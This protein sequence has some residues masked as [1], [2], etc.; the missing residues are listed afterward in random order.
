M[1]L[2]YSELKEYSNELHGSYK[3]IQE[4]FE[5]IIGIKDQLIKT[6]CW[7]GPAFNYY[8]NKITSLTQN[9]DEV[10]LEL[11]KSALYLDKILEDYEI[12]VNSASKGMNEILDYGNGINPGT[13]SINGS[14][15]TT[16]N[17]LLFFIETTSLENAANIIKGLDTETLEYLK[18]NLEATLKYELATKY[19]ITELYDERI[20]NIINYV[21]EDMLNRF[22]ERFDI[23]ISFDSIDA[24][25]DNYRLL[26]SDRFTEKVKAEGVMAYNDGKESVMNLSYGDDIIKA[27]ISHESIHQLSV[28]DFIGEDG[29]I[30][31]ARGF[32]IDEQN[33][34]FNECATEYLNELVMQDDYPAEGYS[35]YS[36]G[37]SK[38][39]K[40]LDAEILNQEKFIES[41]F[42]SD[43]NY[44]ENEI[45]K[46]GGKEMYN[47]LMKNFNDAISGNSEVS[48]KAL[49]NLDAIISNLIALKEVNS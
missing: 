30:H 20:D 28:N 3:N 37:V 49:D 10:Y 5:N 43:I 31:T 1:N 29:Q 27:N 23:Y 25:N 38:L 22:R 44:I 46:I 42:T 21:N 19:Q 11:E 2:S 16:N 15:I 40:L 45:T 34:G 24:I 35:G 41:Y 39:N 8:I 17:E 48:S 32:S 33:T 6:E 9:F 14:N 13:N 18:N 26:N 4:I 36:E 12:L 47:E 7:T